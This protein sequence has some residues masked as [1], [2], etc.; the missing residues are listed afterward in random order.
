MEKDILSVW[1]DRIEREAKHGDKTRACKAADVTMTT[2]QTAMR[3][4]S[5]SALTD[6]EVAALTEM[7]KLLDERAEAVSKLRARYAAVSD[8]NDYAS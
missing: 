3:K 2:Y 7:V 1:K 4:E 6:A 5:F 8:K